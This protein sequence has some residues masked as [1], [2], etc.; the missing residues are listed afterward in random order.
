MTAQGTTDMEDLVEQLEAMD[1]V[2]KTTKI[3]SAA[4]IIGGIDMATFVSDDYSKMDYLSAYK[5]RLPLYDN[6]V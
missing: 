6:E 4:L 3:D 1:G 5:G 2:R